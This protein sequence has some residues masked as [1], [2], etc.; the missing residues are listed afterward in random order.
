MDPADAFPLLRQLADGRFH[1]GE[2]LARSLGLSRATLCQR[3]D[4]LERLGV[5]CH[6]VRGR[7]YRLPYALDLLDPAAL[8]RESRDC[9]LH[10]EAVDHTLSTSSD[11]LARADSLPSGHVRVAEW[12]TAG[13]GRQGRRWLSMPAQGLTFS[14]LWRFEGGVQALT[15]LSLAVAVALA[16]ACQDCGVAGVRLKWPNDLLLQ[17]AVLGDRKFGG[18]LVDVQGDALGPS[19]AVIGVGLNVHSAPPDTGQPVA[20]LAEAVAGLIRQRLLVAALR[21]LAE[22]IRMFDGAGFEPFREPWQALHAW[23]LRN[24]EVLNADGSRVHGVAAGID[25]DGALL[26]ETPAGRMRLLSG[27]IRRCSAAPAS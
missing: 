16:R 1:G 25:T 26:L 8:L 13:R 18:I 6:R 10:I 5:E 11:L 27:D 24:V 7:G 9:G 15:G 20:A 4:A 2:A 19:T 3:I 21:R 23:Q 14:L 22:A 17:H 12:Q